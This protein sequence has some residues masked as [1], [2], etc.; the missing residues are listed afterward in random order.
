MEVITYLTVG[1][2]M[3]ETNFPLELVDP[4][5]APYI[6]KDINRK[7]SLEVLFGE[8]SDDIWV[9]RVMAMNSCDSTSTK[10]FSFNP[11]YFAQ[12]QQAVKDELKL[13]FDIDVP[14]ETV[15]LHFFTL[16]K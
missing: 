1:I 5:V 6:T 9:G 11:E 13:A 4:K 7:Y 2:R 3:R 10:S 15:S 14:V 16:W 12:Y 8:Q